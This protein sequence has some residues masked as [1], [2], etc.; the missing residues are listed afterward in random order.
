MG[1]DYRLPAYRLPAGVIDSAQLFL[2]AIKQG[3]ANSVLDG[4]TMDEAREFLERFF[5]QTIR[6]VDG[7]FSQNLQR[8]EMAFWTGALLG[9]KI[10]LSGYRMRLKELLHQQA[11]GGQVA[12][13][14][15]I[16]T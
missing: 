4:A 5:L 12:A 1:G 8:Y 11:T 3:G 14:P 15:L 16:E 9:E 13:T 6:Q 10:A 2:A 7:N